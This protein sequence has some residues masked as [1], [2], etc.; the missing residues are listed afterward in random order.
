MTFDCICTE[1]V[2]KLLQIIEIC[3]CIPK[4]RMNTTCEHHCRFKNPTDYFSFTISYQSF[5]I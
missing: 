1:T 5:L 4:M 3:N 2:E